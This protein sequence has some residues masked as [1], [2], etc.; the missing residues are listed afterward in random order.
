MPNL[1]IEYLFDNPAPVA[2]YFVKHYE[3][4]LGEIKLHTLLYWAF[5]LTGNAGIGEGGNPSYRLYRPVFT[6]VP[7]GVKEESLDIDEA[8]NEPMAEDEYWQLVASGAAYYCDYLLSKVGQMNDFDMVD[9][10]HK[11]FCWEHSF[12]DGINKLPIG[13]DEVILK[14]KG[15]LEMEE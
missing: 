8:F 3:G 4:N 6:A 12:Q 14:Y 11:D 13:E 9:R 5:A 7:F 2:K 15:F 10:I 1:N